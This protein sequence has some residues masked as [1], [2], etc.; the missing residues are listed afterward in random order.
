M[1]NKLIILKIG[2]SLV[3]HKDFSEPKFNQEA[4][5]RIAKEI[6]A[7]LS[8]KKLIL[9]H[10]GGSFGHPIVKKNNLDQGIKESTQLIEL[11]K[12][13]V[14]QNKLNVL[15]CDALTK[16][17]INAFPFQPSTASIMHD[18]SLKSFNLDVLKNLLKLNIIPVLFGSISFDSSIGCSVLSGDEIIANLVNNLDFNIEKVLFAT[19]VDGIF[20]KDPKIHSDAVKISH[21]S[22]LDQAEIF[23]STS[24]DVTFGMLGKVQKIF[25]YNKTSR[26]FSGKIPNNITKA[27]LG[28]S[29]GTLICQ[30]SLSFIENKDS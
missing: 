15:V 2:G 1:E 23:K 26:I 30:E 20:S 29:I 25:S 3:T 13:Q 28:E 10:G 24:T 22:S 19:D 5:S 6:K 18:K 14:L 12:T 4:M 21:I 8:D 27:L 11:A 9:V 17:G 7:G 16:E